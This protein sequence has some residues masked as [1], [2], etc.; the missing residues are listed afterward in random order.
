[1]Q[2]REGVRNFDIVLL[3]CHRK[4]INISINS[5]DKSARIQVNELIKTS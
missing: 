5:Y 2:Y 1:M 4:F 3:Y